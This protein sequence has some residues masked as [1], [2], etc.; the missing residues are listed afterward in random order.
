[1]RKIQIF[2]KCRF[3]AI[4]HKNII[5]MLEYFANNRNFTIFAT[6]LAYEVQ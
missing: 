2:K 5:F 4:S 6:R 1:M 3:V